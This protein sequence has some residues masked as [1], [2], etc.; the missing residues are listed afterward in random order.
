MIYL[1][2]HGEVFKRDGMWLHAGDHIAS[3]KPAAHCLVF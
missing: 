2:D 3:K 1:S